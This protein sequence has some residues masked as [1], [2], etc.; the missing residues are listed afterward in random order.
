VASNDQAM[1]PGFRDVFAM[2]AGGETVRAYLLFGFL[3]LVLLGIAGQ[4]AFREVRLKT[5][6]NRL[7]L[8][9][10]EAQQIAE[11]VVR[12]G[13]EGGS[14]NYSLVRKNAD[15][16]KNFIYERLSQHDMIHHVEI[17]D[18]FGICQLIVTN[19]P[20]SGRTALPFTSEV[21]PVHWPEGGGHVVSVPL[22]GAEGEVRVGLF[23]TAVL[24]DLERIRHSL[25]IKVGAA[26][27]LAVAVLV[28]GFFYVLYLIRKNRMLEQARQSAE[29]ASYVGLLA[30]N[31]A[32]EIRNPLN[33]MNINVQMLEEEFQGRP[34]LQD[35]DWGELLDLTKQEI[36]RLES[37]AKNFLSYA[38]PAPPNFELGDINEVVRDVVRFLEVDFK[39]SGVE[40]VTALERLLPAVEFDATQLRQALINLIINANQVV[41]SGGRVTVR[42]RPGSSGEVVIEVEDDGP[43]MAP[44]VQERAFEVFYSRRGGGTG[45]GLPIAKQIVERHGG[46][47]GV[48]SV[49]NRG[50]TFT[51]RL[52]RRH[53]HPLEHE[54]GGGV[55]S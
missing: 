23:S 10:H 54:G 3:L 20:R 50:T 9:R 52:P 1:K 30:S 18:R 55:G 37:L 24:S 48:S 46:T 19:R 42:T 12:I 11:A 47:I 49:K 41:P 6:T 51:I 14:I 21:I 7:D 45:L 38:R 25:R 5:V 26:A 28:A 43:G 15:T 53:D 34:D 16:L 35:G 44:E 36:K 2:P 32:H 27:A 8:V 22:A 33:A 40:L 29:R 17:L 39:Q 13:G 31:L 4:L